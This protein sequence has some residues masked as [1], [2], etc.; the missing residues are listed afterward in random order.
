M[1]LAAPGQTN[2]TWAMDFLHDALANGHK[3]R[4]LSIEDAYARKTLVVEVDA[5]LPALGVVRV[6]EKPRVTRRLP[7]RI[8]IDQRQLKFPAVLPHSEL[9][10]NLPLR[11]ITGRVIRL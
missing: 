1:L 11:N 8:V 6:L 4:T 2:E 5:S 3:V 7:A 9:L 10:P